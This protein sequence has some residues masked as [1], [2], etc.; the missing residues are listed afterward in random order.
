M[1]LMEHNQY[2][3]S[4]P[5]LQMTTVGRFVVR[6]IGYFAYGVTCAVMIMFCASD[7]RPLRAAGFLLVLF[8]LDRA[9]HRK[10]SER[11][12]AH[13][14]LRHP[15]VRC[16]TAPLTY[17]L[18]EHS[19]ERALV[20]GG[21]L[22][23]HLLAELVKRPEIRRAFVRMDI[24]VEE[25]TSKIDD[26]LREA[27]VEPN[28][29]K[30]LQERVQVFMLEA[31]KIAQQNFA[32]MIEPV[33]LFSA[34]AA[35][36]DVYVRRL[37]T[38]FDIQADDLSA[39]IVFSKRP[40]FELSGF[41]PKQLRVR[42]RIMNRA[43]TARPTPTLDRFS[44][45]LT[46]VAR[47]GRSGFLIG[48]EKEYQR[49]TDVLGR[50][51]R[52]NALLIGESGVGKDTLIQHLAYQIAH[53]R[54]TKALF[55]KRLV[56]LHAS[57]LLSNIATGELETRLKTIIDEIVRAGNVVL[58]IPDIHQLSKITTE[59]RL[60]A[61]DILLPVF[62]SSNISVIG[63][64]AP[65]EYKQFI[66][67]N[68]EFAG[69]FEEIRVEELSEQEAIRYLAHQSLIL[70]RPHDITI[71]FS[72][73]R[74]AVRLAKKYFRQTMLP[75]SAEDLLKEALAKALRED[76][77]VLTSEEVTSAA[78]G[79]TNVPIK[80]VGTQEAGAL[81]NLENRIHERFIDQQEAVAAVSQALR[82]YRSGLS[83]GKGPIATFLFVGPT[84]VGKTELSKILTQIQFG[85]EE[86]MVRFDMTEYQDKQSFIRF[87]GSPD[88][89]IRGSLT[90]AVAEKPYSLILLDEFEKAHPDILNLFLQVFDE[91]RLTD[92]LGRTVTFNNTIIIATSNAHSTLIKEEIE[93]GSSA[94]M[95][96]EVVKKR[97]TEFFKPELINRFSK[98]V[99]F[100][101]LSID[102]IRK[103][104]ALR[105]NELSRILLETQGI[106]MRISEAA[107]S[108][109]ARLGYDPAFGARP[110]KAVLSEKIR[111][112]LAEKILK[113]ELKKGG[114]VSLDVREGEFVFTPQ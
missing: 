59:S 39:A 102:D 71:S 101:A 106:E 5:R 87:I 19:F 54:T 96:A 95:V 23:L 98:I 31:M 93:K 29:K 81:L 7:V 14:S 103:I 83:G 26:Y 17:S 79:R 69:A 2:Y 65:R 25:V 27:E 111:S 32:T 30:A 90:E 35:S 41:L 73:V 50:V 43:W 67:I 91:G 75:G 42:K 78:E 47:L 113:G 34:V 44:E 61:I 80:A 28:G 86:F 40:V 56:M 13:A 46:A 84:G 74:Q 105:L 108:E 4:D 21:G 94:N 76:K 10:K 9:L 36:D 45:D 33:H 18:I 104:A 37:L 60:S 20:S 88:G 3:F 12:L 100:K 109:V 48:H 97:L 16:Y 114:G 82:E 53:D 110:L 11:L 89:V 66:E 1:E 107:V 92:G 6:L 52:P 57:S 24:K 58:Y 77:K 72:A 51:G 8:F 99:V 62:Q 70:E 22:S 68:S 63:T 112:V 49:L 15:N 64:T 55:D 85:G 38:L